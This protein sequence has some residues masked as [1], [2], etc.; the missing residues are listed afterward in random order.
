MDQLIEERIGEA[1]KALWWAEVVR[2]GLRLLILSIVALLVWVIID[3]WVYSPGRGVRLIAFAGMCVLVVYYAW[4]RVVPLMGSSIRPE[5]AARSLERDLPELRQSLTSY[6]TLRNDLDTA[7]LHGRVIRSMGSITAGRLK[8]YDELPLEATGTLRWWVATAA[9][10]ALLVAYGVVSPKNTLQSASRLVA[11]LAAIDPARRVS[12]RDVEPGDIEA[13][14]GRDVEVSAVV[15][16]LR[17]DEQVYCRWDLTSGRSEIVLEYDP[18]ANRYSGSLPLAHSANGEVPYTVHAGDAVSGPF[19]LRV[20]N[21]PV[22]ALQSVQYQPPQYTGESPHTS[23]SGAITALDGTRVRIL[24]NTNR[25]V[26]KAKIEFN[27]RP[28]GKTIQAT[29]GATE[30]EIDSGGTNLSVEFPLRSSRGRSA[31][32]EY[33]RYRI[34][35]WDNAGQ[36]NPDPIIYPIRV[37]ADLPPEVSITMPFRSP[38]DVPVDAQQ[39]I[40]VHASDPDYGL[41]QI[42]IEIRSG[43]D[44]IG[45]PILWSDPQGA[46]GNRVSEYRFRPAAHGLKIGDTVQITAVAIDNRE[47]EHDPSVEP[48]VTRT[49][50]V[51]LKITATAPLPRDGDPSGGGLSEPD[52][53]PASDHATQQ[54]QSGGGESGESQSGEGQS[55]EGQSGEGQSGEGQSGEGQSGEGQTGEGQAV[56]ASQSSIRRRA[57]ESAR[58]SLKVSSSGEFKSAS[59]ENQAADSISSG[60]TRSSTLSVTAWKPSMIED[61]K[62]QGWEE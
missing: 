53:R 10:L 50:P 43:I 48:N 13:I 31:A 37:I 62:G 29:A 36:R 18:S 15:D 38:K 14:A 52:Q 4:R 8:S 39:V 26:T 56:S 2:S 33:E 41:K 44:R 16:G 11:P 17:Q 49:D 3:Q 54:E 42:R 59:R 58:G 24:A 23:G 6:L 22:V 40:E 7:S 46:K 12:I 60:F 57:M 1:C 55:G 61:G 34:S 32:V 51:E 47:I 35:V 25:P 45:D 27:P 5:Y 20:E 28:L 19:L 30:M 9:A 21:V